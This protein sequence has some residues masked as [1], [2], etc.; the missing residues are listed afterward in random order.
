MK[1]SN[2]AIPR[3]S[4]PKTGWP[5]AAIVVTAILLLAGGAVSQ[6]QYSGMIAAGGSHSLALLA[7]GTVKAW[8]ANNFGELGL[9][10]TTNFTTP[11]II[12]GLNGVVVVAA[13]D[14]HS[15][16][17]VADG[18]V[19]AWG[20]NGSGQLGLGHTTG[21]ST[22]QCIPGLSGVSAVTAGGFMSF[23]LLANGTVKAWGANSEGQLGLGHI[24]NQSTPQNIPGLTN[25][26]AL[27]GGDNHALAL[28]ANGTV[29]AWG[30]GGVGQLGLGT[31]YGYWPSP[32]GIPGLAGVVA[33]AA[34]AEHSLAL[35][36]SGL[37]MSWGSGNEGQLGLGGTANHNTPQGVLGGVAAVDAGRFHSLAVLADGTVKAWGHN[38]F[39]QLGLGG[40]VNQ[41]TPQSIAGL[42]NAVSVTAGGYHSLALLANGAVRAWGYNASGQLG[43]GGNS[44][45]QGPIFVVEGLALLGLVTHAPAASPIGMV[46]AWDLNF[47]GV[48]AAGTLY[49]FDVSTAGSSPGITV[50]GLG[51]FPLNRPLLN[52]D[53]GTL[54]APLLINFVG[55][56]D[57]SG[58]AAPALAVPHIPSL[59]GVTLNGAAV[60]L[61]PSST[62]Q[63]AALTQYAAVTQLV[64]PVAGVN[65]VF[66]ASVLSSGGESLTI[67]G[68]GFVPGVAVTLGGIAATSVVVVDQWT[69]TCSAP[70]HPPGTGSVVVT[71]PGVAAGTWSG[72]FTWLAPVINGVTPNSGPAAG[73][74]IVSINGSSF[75][76]NAAVMFGYSTSTQVTFQNA[77]L[78]NCAAPPHVSGTPTTVWV[79]VTNPGGVSALMSAAFTYN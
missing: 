25:V 68:T 71:N 40:T 21:Q 8:G 59:I 15:L 61:N 45:Q 11:Q 16:A 6:T 3:E 2:C 17:M 60:A 53:H 73:G 33:L 62:L 64:A 76:P 79:S 1:S 44:G 49:W 50:P 27:A 77:G 58:N 54:L 51:V 4:R 19:K 39:G 47:I 5:L 65:G 23:A 67:I 35:L 70:A 69:I 56:L 42:N 20:H 31:N 13:G 37:V 66:P 7:N 14:R 18:T 78:I 63:V 28:L 10:N 55:L 48:G 74:T 72:Q 29:A 26:V 43:V 34:G 46:C 38:Y 9:G 32:I 41:T 12:P 75:H 57:A 52:L 24:T 36:S 30:Y 22:P